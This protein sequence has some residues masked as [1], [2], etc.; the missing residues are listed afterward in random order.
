M[1]RRR[2]RGDTLAEINITPL[3]DVLLVLLVIFMVTA[4]MVHHGARL[5]TPDVS[6]SDPQKQSKDEEKATLVVDRK[7]QILFRKKLISKT[8]LFEFLKKNQ[9]LQQQQE[10]YIKADPDLDYGVV[11]DI[12]GTAR[13]AGIRKLGVVVDPVDLLPKAK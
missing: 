5:A 7:G 1:S 10:L 4:P 9:Q 12:F 2:K 13:R 3:V 6:P 11:M 8:G